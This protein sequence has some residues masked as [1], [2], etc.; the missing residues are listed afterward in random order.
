MRRSSGGNWA[1][2]KYNPVPGVMETAPASKGYAGGFGTDLMLKDLGLAQDSATAVQ[3]AIRAASVNPIDIRVRKG[4]LKRLVPYTFPL[5]M[6]TDL[7][8]VVTAVGADVRRFA[9]GDA[10]YARPNRLRIGSFAE[11]IAVHRDEVAQKPQSL[12]FEEAASLPLVALTSRQA[13]WTLPT[14]SPGTRC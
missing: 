2:E 8:G 4:E 7:A 3:A 5:R 11:R 14:S 13:M 6:G 1:L 12:G 10:V 9:V